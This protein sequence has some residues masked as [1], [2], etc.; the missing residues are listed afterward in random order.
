MDIIGIP[1]FTTIHM[2][3]IHMHIIPLPQAIG[4]AGTGP[5]TDIIAIIIT[6]AIDLKL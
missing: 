5:T 6:T 3:G 2:L 1:T 4:I